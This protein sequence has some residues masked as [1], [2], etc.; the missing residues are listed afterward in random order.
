MYD[1]NTEFKFQDKSVKGLNIERYL[2]SID[3]N[4]FFLEATHF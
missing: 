3:S 2:I 1:H 4:F